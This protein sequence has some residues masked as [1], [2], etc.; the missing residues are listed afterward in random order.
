MS[1]N[2]TVE[3]VS[4]N[5]YSSTEEAVLEQVKVLNVEVPSSDTQTQRENVHHCEIH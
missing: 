3:K 2:N 1:W 4:E 5:D